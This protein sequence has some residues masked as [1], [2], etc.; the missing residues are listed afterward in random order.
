ML[1]LCFFVQEIYGLDLLITGCN[2]PHLKEECFCCFQEELFIFYTDFFNRKVPAG[3][4]LFCNV[5]L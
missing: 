4:S 3:F 1:L 2:L 5:P